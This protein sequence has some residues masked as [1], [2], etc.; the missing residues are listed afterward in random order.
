MSDSRREFWLIGISFFLIYVVW[1]STYLGNAWGVLSVPPFLFASLRFILAG[2][3]LFAVVRFQRDYS[4][5]WLQLRN[6]AIAG[7]LLFA[8]GNGLVTWALQHVDSGMASLIVAFQP[9]IVVFLMWVMRSQHPS[10]YSW[11]GVVIGIVGMYL[12][13]G[14]PRFLNSPE[15]RMGVWA[16]IVALVAW[17]VCLVWMKDADLPRSIFLSAALQMT[18]G[19]IMMVGISYGVGEWQGFSWV[20]VQPIAL[21]SLVY[22]VIFGS[23]LAFTAFNYL[24]KKVSPD[25]VSTSTFINPIV[26]LLLGSWLNQE[27]ITE[28]SIFAAVLLLTGVLFIN[29]QVRMLVRWASA[30]KEKPVQINRN[31]SSS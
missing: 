31:K 3:I 23:V 28:R 4:V 29:G 14:Q 24:V 5:T 25:K 7:L 2:L 16:I 8:I 22:L 18:F 12:L 27:V 9:L 11:V 13:T 30:K 26:A 15:W 19:G 17:G 20:Q 21:W 1:G 6:T 10:G